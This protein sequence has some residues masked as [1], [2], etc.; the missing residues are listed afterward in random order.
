MI[1]EGGRK[2]FNEL[3]YAM[4]THLVTAF[5]GEGVIID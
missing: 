5:M 3:F 4:T 2:G 1:F